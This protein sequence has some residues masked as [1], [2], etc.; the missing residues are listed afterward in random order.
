MR[1]DLDYSL[2]IEQ[3]WNVQFHMSCSYLLRGCSSYP[4]TGSARSTCTPRPASRDVRGLR[5]CQSCHAEIYARW[6]K[7]PMA[8]VVRD[9]RE[10]PEA[11]I[12]DLATNPV[13]KFTLDD[14]GLVCGSIWKQRYFTKIGNDYYPQPSQWDVTNHVWRPYFVPNDADWWAPRASDHNAGGTH[15]SSR[16][17]SGE[18]MCELPYAGDR[19][20]DR[21]RQRACAHVCVHHTGNDGEIQTPE[22]LYFLPDE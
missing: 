20:D 17:D 4:R 14:V 9:P 3:P 12:P 22:S 11:I 16:G 6:Q 19:D 13:K 1:C 7:T 21:K 2:P 8:N 15:P 5:A 18:R 10:H